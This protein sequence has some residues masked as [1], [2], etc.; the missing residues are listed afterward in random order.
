MLVSDSLGFTVL[1]PSELCYPI[2]VSNPIVQIKVRSNSYKS[3]CSLERIER[4]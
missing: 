4:S 1:Q 3:S 2:L